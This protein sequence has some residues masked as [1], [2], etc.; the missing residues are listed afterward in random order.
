MHTIHSHQGNANQD[1]SAMAFCTDFEAV[2]KNTHT[3]TERHTHREN[4]KCVENWK[5]ET[6]RHCWWER[7]MVQ[8]LWEMV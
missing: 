7:K 5:G 1:F 2:M 3:Q 6:L 8:M 4:N